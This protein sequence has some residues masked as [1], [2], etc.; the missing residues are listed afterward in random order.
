MPDSPPTITPEDSLCAAHYYG[1]ASECDARVEAA[2]MRG[3][4]AALKAVGL[5]DEKAA[6]DIKDMRAL[7]S[8][9]RD[10]KSEVW[11]TILHWTVTAVLAGIA[12]I[13]YHKTGEIKT[14]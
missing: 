13:V 8:S 12:F 14:P 4:A 3:V 9:W 5:G 6:E 7:L 10:T 2:A 11:K 1:S